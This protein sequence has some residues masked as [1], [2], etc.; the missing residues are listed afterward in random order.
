MFCI[1]ILKLWFIF[2]VTFRVNKFIPIELIF[3]SKSLIKIFQ[4]N[5]YGYAYILFIPHVLRINN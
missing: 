1:L 5:V 2:I 3:F 4:A